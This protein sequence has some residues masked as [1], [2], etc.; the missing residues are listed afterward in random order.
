MN[1]WSLFSKKMS[2]SAS[3]SVTCRHSPFHALLPPLWTERRVCMN[4]RHWNFTPYV[5]CYKI[6]GNERAW[7]TFVVVS[8]TVGIVAF[9]INSFVLFVAQVNAGTKLKWHLSDAAAF[10]FHHIHEFNKQEK[11][12][13]GLLTRAAFR[14]TLY[15][16]SSKFRS[17][18]YVQQKNN[19]L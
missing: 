12:A 4:G 2:Q 17:C 14:Y 9:S 16:Q 10:V 11:C 6:G 13:M 7:P 8:V 5:M 19:N 1:W 18:E 3:P 15:I